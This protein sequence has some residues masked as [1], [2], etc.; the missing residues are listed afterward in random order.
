MEEILTPVINALSATPSLAVW[1]LVVVYAYKAIVVGS[2]Y[3][4]IRFCVTQLRVVMTTP[5][6]TLEKVEIEAKLRSLT[7]PGCHEDL[8]AQIDR[9]SGVHTGVSTDKAYMNKY[10]HAQDVRWLREAIDAKLEK[11]ANK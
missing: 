2:I 8:I 11:D 4:V 3:G 1:A 5:K 9:L 6:H 10:I 7:I